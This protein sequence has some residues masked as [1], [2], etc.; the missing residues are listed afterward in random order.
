MQNHCKSNNTKRPPKTPDDLKRPQMTWKEPITNRRSK[1]KGGDPGD[2]PSQWIVFVEQTF[3]E[4][5]D[6]EFWI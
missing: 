6:S 5:L 4:S 2:N 3:S 1:L